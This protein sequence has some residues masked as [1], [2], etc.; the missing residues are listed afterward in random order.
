LNTGFGLELFPG[1]HLLKSLIPDIRTVYARTMPYRSRQEFLH[2]LGYSSIYQLGK[3]VCTV[4]KV[5]ELRIHID[6][7]EYFH[8]L[9]ELLERAEHSVYIL[10]WDIDSRTALKKSPEGS[11]Q[12][13]SH[14]FFFLQ[15]LIKK[16]PQLNIY[17]LCW[18]YSILFS[19]ER[20]LWPLFKPQAWGERIHFVLDK[21]HPLL[22]SHHQKVVVVDDK[23]A[24]VGGVDLCENRYDHPEHFLDDP[25][26]LNALGKAYQPWHDIHCML[27]GPLSKKI[28]LL[29]RARWTLA[30]G[31]ELPP[32]PYESNPEELPLPLPFPG[33]IRDQY[34]G[35]CRTQP[36]YKKQRR[37]RENFSATIELIRKS[38]KFIY[39]EN[40]YLTS[41]SI[42][43]AL[44]RSLESP[45]G[46]EIVVILPKFPFGWRENVTIAVLQTRVLRKLKEKD[47]YNRFKAYYPQ[48]ISRESNYL[49]VHSKLILVDDMFAKIGSTNI[50]NR[51]MGLDTEM[52]LIWE[53]QDRESH[54][55]LIDL[56]CQL[57]AEHTGS[58]FSYV[59]KKHKMPLIQ[60]VEELSIGERRLEAHKPTT[61][62][63]LDY[64]IPHIPF[65]DSPQPIH[66]SY[67]VFYFWYRMKAILRRA[68]R[69]P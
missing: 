47:N 25:R 14:L 11:T 23:Y 12:K 22:S 37:A 34:V 52:D 43:K 56:R 1:A 55:A 40:Q 8:C 20:E 46:P 9:S 36:R 44:E 13:D 48:L 31:K 57:I 3:T 4:D 29:C 42:R 65:F 16:K 28:G 50:N 62:D 45:Q 33:Q 19:L 10:G 69:R 54:E 51:S 67:L 5:H 39:I 60:L 15:N 59:R 18:N 35:V 38:K 27:S 53:A 66:W 49:Y 26:R 61:S 68:H 17:L 63:W 58:E 7:A 6:A 32:P 41:R 2:R 24:C 64:L 30:T 21:Y